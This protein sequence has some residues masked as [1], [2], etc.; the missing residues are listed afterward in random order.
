MLHQLRKAAPSVDFLPVN[1]HASCPY[2][3]MITPAA[4]LRCLEL[5]QDEVTVP[6]DIADRARASVEAMIS[7]GNPGGGE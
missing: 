6:A 3:K 7:I 5:E 1:E 4:L 2:M